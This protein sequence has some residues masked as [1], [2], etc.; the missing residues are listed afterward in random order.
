MKKLL[1]TL[2]CGVALCALFIMMAPAT[3]A[4]GNIWNGAPNTNPH[5][6]S[7]TAGETI[8]SNIDRACDFCHTPHGSEQTAGYG[9]SLPLWNRVI[10]STT[11]TPYNNPNGTIDAVD[12]D[13][14]L[15]GASLA[16]LSCHDGTNTLDELVN[17]PN[18]YPNVAAITF[19]DVANRI[20]GE[21]LDA[22]NIALIGTSLVDDH[23]VGFTNP[24]PGGD[25]DL[26]AI[27]AN[28]HFGVGSDQV[29]CASCHQVHFYS[30]VA[31]ETPF[32]RATMA[33]NALCNTCHEK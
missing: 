28:F 19:A 15:G 20:T 8:I 11:F 25:A 23:P 22:A 17:F 26:D 7:S 31:D 1:L 14:D 3:H 9:A 21:A 16:C 33:G 6:L 12:I 10:A 2:A 13:A 18:P 4:I 30:L 27:D 29:E 24:G 5:N 32:L